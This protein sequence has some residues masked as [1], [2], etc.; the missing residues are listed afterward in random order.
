M[1]EI[2]NRFQTSCPIVSLEPYGMGHINRTYLAVASDGKKY[3]LQKINDTVFTDVDGLM[4]NICGVTEYVAER[5]QKGEPLKVIPTKG[6]A[7]YLRVDEG[8]FRMYNFLYGQAVETGATL[9]QFELAGKGFGRFQRL[10]DGYPSGKLF[11]TIKYFHNT[12]KRFEAFVKAVK[13]DVC[14]R[15]DFCRE[16]IEFFISRKHYCRRVLDLLENGQIPLR[17]T[18]NDTKPNNVLVEESQDK[19]VA[20]IDLD[21]IMPGSMLYDFGDSIRYGANTAAEDE[22]DLTKVEFSKEYFEAYCRGFLPEV[23]DMATEC[24]KANLHF[25]AIL[26]TYECG[27][28]FLTDHLS[29]DAYFRIHREGHNLDR[30]RTQIALAKDMERNEQYMKDTVKKYLQ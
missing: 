17:V 27:M 26:L 23:K 6:G 18:H 20:I 12:E 21:T 10:L 22:K 16:E 11:E 1:L 15:A 28:R 9:K 19:V 4:S 14:G 24:E 3:V 5:T 2:A 29:G 13:D 8:C 25:G 7:P 30:C